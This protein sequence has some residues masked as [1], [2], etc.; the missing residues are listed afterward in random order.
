MDD[1]LGLD[2]ACRAWWRN[3]HGC[4]GLGW[5]GSGRRR[6]QRSGTERRLLAYSCRGY[7]FAGCPRVRCE[8]TFVYMCWGGCRCGCGCVV[9]CPYCSTMFPSHGFYFLRYQITRPQLAPVRRRHLA[10]PPGGRV[11]LLP[12]L[13]LPA[14]RCPL[15]AARCPLPTHAHAHTHA[16]A[17]P[18]MA[19]QVCGEHDPV[20][21]HG[22]FLRV[23][24]RARSAR[25]LQ[26]PPQAALL[27]KR[28]PR[29][30]AGASHRVFDEC[31][32]GLGCPPC[33]PWPLLCVAPGAVN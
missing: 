13:P 2:V 14:A 21:R 23:A 7:S 30:Q 28:Q 5:A 33:W 16:R 4:G 3:H 32:G 6:R 12:P 11:R 29:T 8:H 17:H 25:V 18:C 24:P 22:R 9:C 15:P 31:Q 27:R 10:R 19:P 1:D 20:P 26:R